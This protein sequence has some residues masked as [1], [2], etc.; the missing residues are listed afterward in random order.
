M[1][2]QQVLKDHYDWLNNNGGHRANLSY[3]DL[4]GANLRRADLSDAD[5]S[6][7]DLS[8]ANL[9][10]ANLRR[11]NLRRADLSYADLSYADLS[12]ADLRRA[13]LSGA[14][15]SGANLSGANLIAGGQNTRGYLFYAYMDD[16]A[17]ILRAGCRRF[18]LQQ[19]KD[20][21]NN[22]HDDDPVLKEDCISIVERIERM[23]K[24]RGWI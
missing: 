10:Y 24:V 1:N 4:S 21:W 20:H 19:A 22:A 6:Y 13:N 23:A 16:N 3:A 11:A 8:G 17:L 7:A 12:G 9:R 18:T 5:L 14:N 2:L 15:L